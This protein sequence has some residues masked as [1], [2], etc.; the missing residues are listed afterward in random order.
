M[1][2]QTSFAGI[3]TWEP[4]CI[5]SYAAL[6]ASWTQIPIGFNGKLHAGSATIPR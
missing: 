2:D 3:F 5:P 6:Q 1:A 4:C